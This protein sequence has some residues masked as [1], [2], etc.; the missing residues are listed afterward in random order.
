MALNGTKMPFHV[1]DFGNRTKHILI[2]STKLFRRNFEEWLV[3][4]LSV[5]TM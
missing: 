5:P 4:D 3:A 1:A 2:L